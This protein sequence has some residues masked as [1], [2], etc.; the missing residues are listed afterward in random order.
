MSNAEE[1]FY[2]NRASLTGV[3]SKNVVKIESHSI[4]FWLELLDPDNKV[5]S[6]QP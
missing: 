5:R 6:R 1:E 2:Q 3:A 4:M